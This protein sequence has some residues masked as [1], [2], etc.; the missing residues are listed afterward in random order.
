ML[1]DSYGNDDFSVLRSG[2]VI[3]S[4]DSYSV[5]KVMSSCD[6]YNVDGDVVIE[7]EKSDFEV[8]ER[9]ELSLDMDPS[10]EIVGKRENWTESVDWQDLVVDMPYLTNNEYGVILPVISTTNGSFKENLE[11]AVFCP[12]ESKDHLRVVFDQNFLNYDESFLYTDF[13][14]LADTFI[15][16][17][18]KERGFIPFKTL[19]DNFTDFIDKGII[20][21][22]DVRGNTP[23]YFVTKDRSTV[24]HWKW[25]NVKME[26]GKTYYVHLYYYTDNYISSFDSS[27]SSNAVPAIGDWD[28][29]LEHGSELFTSCWSKEFSLKNIPDYV[30]LLDPGTKNYVEYACD[31]VPES[32]VKVDMQ[33]GKLTNNSLDLDWWKENV[34]AGGFIDKGSQGDSFNFDTSSLDGLF[35]S[36][37]SFFD[38]LKKGFS[39]VPAFMWYLISA[40]IV[41]IIF[42]RIMGR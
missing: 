25:E 18:L 41:V 29:F 13:E 19:Y 26:K 2:F 32:G 1:G 39:I 10:V 27:V 28:Q 30:P 35:N 34:G 21:V 23:Y 24:I 36:C 4:N 6:I 37:K 8:T 11:N 20:T 42:L 17:S 14:G 12:V 3:N 7:H 38:F 31:L 16:S 9:P 40:S 5:L 33:S 22:Y 15:Y